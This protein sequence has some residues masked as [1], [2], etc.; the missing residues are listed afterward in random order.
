M[1]LTLLWREGSF[2]VG[3]ESISRLLLSTTRCAGQCRVFGQFWGCFLL[4]IAEGG[5]FCIAAYFYV[6]ALIST[7]TSAS[8]PHYTGHV[9]WDF[10]CGSPNARIISFHSFIGR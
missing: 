9:F 5:H 10:G 6:S 1:I 3:C 2:V 7:A 4:R 8:V